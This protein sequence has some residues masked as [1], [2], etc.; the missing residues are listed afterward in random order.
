MTLESKPKTIGGRIYAT[1]TAWGWSQK[2]LATYV[3]VDQAS[4]SLWERGKIYPSG[5]SFVALCA[6]F[7]VGR[8]TLTT[9]SE[10]VINETHADIP[11][12][13]EVRPA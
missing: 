9:G 5:S 11:V 13:K 2:K 10:W 4:V 8:Y 12:F 6:L 7:G 3:G 1:R